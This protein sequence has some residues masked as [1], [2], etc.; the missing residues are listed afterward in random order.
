MGEKFILVTGASQNHAKSLVNMIDSFLHFYKNNESAIIVVYDLGINRSYWNAIIAK[1]SDVHNIQY[2]VFDYSKYPA[3][4]NINI[5]A[6]EYAWKPVIISDV[7]DDY[8]GVVIWMDAGNLITEKL[9]KLCEI[10]KTNHIY[11]PI[12]SENIE[13]WT[14]PKTIDYMGCSDTSKINR[15]GAC[16]ALNNSTDWVKT[17]I[18]EFKSL[19]LIKECIAPLGSSRDNHRQDQA[20]FT[21]LY[22]QYQEKY[23]FKCCDE[24]L[25]YTV[26]NDVH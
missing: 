2:R 8:D 19:A 25:E 12:S 24:Y 9:D 23:G 16:I 10:T 20:V 14:Y 5:N 3:Y 4:L 7:C 15:N 6:G 21:I 13:C 11:S 1:Y 18:K 17:F 22:Y 26:H